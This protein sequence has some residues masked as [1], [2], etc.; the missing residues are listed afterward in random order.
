MTT[1]AMNTNPR[2][3][4]DVVKRSVL[5]LPTKITS[6]ISDFQSLKFDMTALCRTAVALQDDERDSTIMPFPEIAWSSEDGAAEYASQ[7]D[8]SRANSSDINSSSEA[9][10]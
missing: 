5:H 3:A 6:K 10:P 9:S 2:P 7:E 1:N 8:V 4:T